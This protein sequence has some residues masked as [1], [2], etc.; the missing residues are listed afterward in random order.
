VNILL[1][2]YSRKGHNEKLAHVIRDELTARGHRVEV[3]VIKPVKR[4]YGYANLSSNWFVLMS[5]TMPGVPLLLFSTFIKRLKRYYQFEVNIAPPLH[6]DVSAFDRVVIGGPKWTH[7]SF[8]V[9][10]YLREVK[11][12]QKVGG[13]AV[14]CGSPLLKNFEI[15]GY[16]SPFNRLVREAGGEVIAQLGISSGY[17]DIL[18]L[19]GPWFRMVCHLRFGRPLSDFG[20]ESEWGR[21]QIERFCDMLEREHVPAEQLLL[22]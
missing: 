5:Q 6:P 14:F 3:E 7:L 12:L 17:T 15:Y 21:A 1:A 18:L 20:M 11:G 2:Y 19:P 16:F 13:F 8:P 22:P 4:S 10:R 9:A